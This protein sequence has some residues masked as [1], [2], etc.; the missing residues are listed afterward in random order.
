MLKIRQPDRGISVRLFLR[1]VSFSS[2]AK[3]GLDTRGGPC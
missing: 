1:G 3:F 2:I